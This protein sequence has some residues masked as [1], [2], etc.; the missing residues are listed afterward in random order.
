MI[1]EYFLNCNA[2]PLL[3]K[4]IANLLPRIPFKGNA[5]GLKWKPRINSH[6]EALFAEESL[7]TCWVR[8]ILHFVQDDELEDILPLELC[9]SV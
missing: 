1:S 3:C 8:G 5:I 4:M 9:S 7:S 2:V 6:S